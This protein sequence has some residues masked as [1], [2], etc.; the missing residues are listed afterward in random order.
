MKWRQA[1]CAMERKY[2]KNLIEFSVDALRFLQLFFTFRNLLVF[3]IWCHIMFNQIFYVFLNNYYLRFTIELKKSFQ[4]SKIENFILLYLGRDAK[5]IYL[6]NHICCQ[7]IKW[8]L[9]WFFSICWNRWSGK[10]SFC[11]LESDHHTL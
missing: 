9:N 3:R 4:L 10:W 5:E 11:G 1:R 7:R 2:E 8:S 6:T